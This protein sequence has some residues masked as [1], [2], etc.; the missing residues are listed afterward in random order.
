VFVSQSPGFHG[1]LLLIDS[2]LVECARGRETIK[3]SA[4]A[5]LALTIQIVA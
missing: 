4:L 1:D 5:G 2:T 3:R